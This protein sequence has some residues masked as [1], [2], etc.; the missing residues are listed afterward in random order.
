MM[1]ILKYNNPFYPWLNWFTILIFARNSLSF[2]SRKLFTVFPNTFLFFFTWGVWSFVILFKQSFPWQEKKGQKSPWSLCKKKKY[3]SCK[4]AFRLWSEMY[5][6]RENVASI[7]FLYIWMLKLFFF[8]NLS[9][10]FINK[11]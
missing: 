3:I 10:N 8:V 6:S 5:W 2:L 1:Y 4:L 7:F 11:L 9:D